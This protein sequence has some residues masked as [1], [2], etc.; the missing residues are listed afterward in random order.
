MTAEEE[1]N[2]AATILAVHTAMA[3]LTE[4]EIERDPGARD[5]L[6]AFTEA[7]MTRLV[8]L[9]PDLLGAAQAACGVVARAADGMPTP[10]MRLHA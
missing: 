2:G 6:L 10:P 3:W 4:R 8:R 1:T 9:H 5:S 7:R